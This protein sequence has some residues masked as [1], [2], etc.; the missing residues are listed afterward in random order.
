M[1]AAGLAADDA[2]P[3]LPPQMVTTG[4]PALIAPV[5]SPDAIAGSGPTETRLR[6]S[7]PAASTST[8]PGMARPPARPGRSIPSRPGRGRGSRDGLG[9]RAASRL[10][11]RRGSASSGSR[12]PWDRDRA[13]EPPRGRAGRR[14]GA[15]GRQ[16]DRYRH[17]RAAPALAVPGQRSGQA[18]AFRA[19][20]A[21][22]GPDV[23]SSRTADTPEPDQPPKLAPGSP[24]V[25]RR[26]GRPRHRHQGGKAAR[27]AARA[28][29]R[30]GSGRRLFAFDREIGSRFVAGVTKP[31]VVPWPAVGG[32]AGAVRP[33]ASHA[34]GP[35]RAQQAE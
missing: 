27:R 16:R 34:G 32:A 30:A 24:P 19:P 9:R 31:A 2:D 17:R 28:R 11:P 23:G 1:A 21:I 33:R 12:S 7:I 29:R 18:V 8:S 14:A 20:R 13:P 6:R 3:S 25:G 35:S 26:A 22:I 5:A 4:L 15:G 10:S